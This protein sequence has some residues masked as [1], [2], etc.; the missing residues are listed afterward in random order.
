[1]KANSVVV[2]V[3]KKSIDI[4][5]ATSRKGWGWWQRSRKPRRRL[6]V[7]EG[8]GMAKR[9]VGEDCDMARVRGRGGAT[10][11]GDIDTVE[12]ATMIGVACGRAAQ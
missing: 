2:L 10:E 1:V 6:E 8:I 4:E 3:A 7:G 5:G 12:E 11:R 9:G